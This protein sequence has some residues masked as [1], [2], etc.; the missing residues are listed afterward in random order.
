MPDCA[1]TVCHRLFGIMLLLVVVDADDC[2]TDFAIYCSNSSQLCTTLA[3]TDAVD[4]QMPLI[5]SDLL[6]VLCVCDRLCGSNA[7]YIPDSHLRE[8][9]NKMVVYE[10]I[11]GYQKLY[12]HFTKEIPMDYSA[13]KEFD[14]VPHTW[15]SL[16]ASGCVP[17][18]V[19]SSLSH[20]APFNCSLCLQLSVNDALCLW[21]VVVLVRCGTV[22]SI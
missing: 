4:I 12:T 21:Y 3:H 11:G 5:G 7:L 13:L 2:S 19:S 15:W 16:R 9:F 22:C 10:I 6:T 1:L 14:K 20:F 18:T 8:A 17:L